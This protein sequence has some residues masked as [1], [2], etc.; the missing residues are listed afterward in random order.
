MTSKRRDL[1]Q[2]ASKSPIMKQDLLKDLRSMIERTQ[3]S[4]SSAIN[5]SLTFFIGM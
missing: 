5:A 1:Q 2:K 3:Q 4:I